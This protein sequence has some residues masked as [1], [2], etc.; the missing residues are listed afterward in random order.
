MFTN[1]LLFLFF[2]SSPLSPA[3]L[4]RTSPPLFSPLFFPSLMCSFNILGMHL[5]GRTVANATVVSSARVSF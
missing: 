5:S 1:R 4:S 2:S 3:S